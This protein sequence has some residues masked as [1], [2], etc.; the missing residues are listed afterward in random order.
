MKAP[1]HTT[2]MRIIY[3]N[4]RWYDVYTKRKEGWVV[5]WVQPKGSPKTDTLLEKVYMKKPTQK[6][7]AN[8]TP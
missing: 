2:P 6:Q 3:K 4:G 7:V 1:R 8:D 5:T